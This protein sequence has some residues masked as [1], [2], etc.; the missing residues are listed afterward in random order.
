[1]FHVKFIGTV[2]ARGTRVSSSKS[3]CRHSGLSRAVQW[4]PGELGLDQE[5]ARLRAALPR[6]A[7]RKC[8]LSCTSF[9][10]L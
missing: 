2:F 9:L 5:H 8:T 1:M 7:D 3:P 10:S 4:E 6:T